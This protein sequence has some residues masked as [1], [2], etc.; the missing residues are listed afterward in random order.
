MDE[1]DLRGGRQRDKHGK[2]NNE[3]KHI[4]SNGQCWRAARDEALAL[5]K[6]KEDERM[7]VV[8]ADAAKKEQTK[9]KKA[10]DTAA[11]VTT[12]SDVMK[13]L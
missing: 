5:L 3:Q 8:A 10:K 9:E 6:E 11:L 13:R 1:N 7:A 12:G 4:W 2:K